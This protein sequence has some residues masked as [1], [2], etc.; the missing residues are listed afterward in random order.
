MSGDDERRDRAAAISR[1]EL[2]KSGAAIGAAALPLG[3]GCSSDTGGDEPPGELGPETL[4]LHG[5]ASGDPL[6]DAVILWTRVSP[7]RD[8]TV[9]VKWTIASDPEFLDVVASGSFE[10]SQERDFT[11]KVDAAG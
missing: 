11:V 7:Q 5:V 8:G 2:L 3:T 4:F 9:T 1:R 6:P 10:T